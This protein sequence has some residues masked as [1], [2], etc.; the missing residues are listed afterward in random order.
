VLHEHLEIRSMRV[1]IGVKSD[2]S[3][4]FALSLAMSSFG[5][6]FALR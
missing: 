2:L 4:D 6:I 3:S 1:A 5:S